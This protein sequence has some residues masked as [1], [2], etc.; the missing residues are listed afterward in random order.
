VRGGEAR[1]ENTGIEEAPSEEGEESGRSDN[2]EVN[3]EVLLCSTFTTYVV[4]S[5]YKATINACS[6]AISPTLDV[7]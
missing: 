2:D 6:F 3:E 1:E 7:K 4:A 5:D